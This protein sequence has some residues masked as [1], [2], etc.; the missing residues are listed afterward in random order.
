MIIIRFKTG[1]VQSMKQLSQMWGSGDGRWGTFE[2]KIESHRIKVVVMKMLLAV[3]T[4]V[5]I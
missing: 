5:A 2:A 3:V 4:T 1:A